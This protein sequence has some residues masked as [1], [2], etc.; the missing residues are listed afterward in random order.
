MEYVG[1]IWTFG[2]YLCENHCNIKAFKVSMQEPILWP[3]WPSS[4]LD[5]D[6]LSIMDQN[7]KVLLPDTQNTYLKP[8]D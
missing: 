2:D 5:R 6:H 8:L 1:Y 7:E 4:K 3:Q